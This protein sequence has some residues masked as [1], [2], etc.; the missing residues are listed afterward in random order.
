MSEHNKQKHKN[1]QNGPADWTRREMLAALAG[2]ASAAL[3][4]TAHSQETPS[5]QKQEPPADPTKV[6]GMAPSARGERSPFETL[7]RIA[8]FG[9][10]SGTP[11]HQLHGTL[12]PSDLH[13]ERHHA[14]IPKIDPSNHEL[15]IHGLVE[16][17][18]KLSM[19]DL[20][21]FPAV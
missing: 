4:G 11:L 13:F 1:N 5:T 10:I 6:P 18:I 14:G 9:V 2:T 12:T 7:E 8:A 17:P 3:A 20:L 15:M 19:S 21:R 16:R